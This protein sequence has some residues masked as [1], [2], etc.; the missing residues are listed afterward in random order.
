MDELLG[1][2]RQEKQGYINLTELSEEKR[3]SIIQGNV[4]AL[5]SISS[6]E[7]EVTSELKNLENKRVNIL[8]DMA[9]VLGKDDEDITISKM[10]EMLERQPGEQAKLIQAKDELVACASKMQIA[11]QQNEILLRHAMEM[12]EFDLTLLKSLKQAPE[13]A[14]YDKNAYNTGEILGNSGFDTKQ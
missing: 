10:I 9:V 1:V 6:K 12:V 8:K 3:V 7:Q 14:N 4:E 11:N 2:L 5:D 13:T